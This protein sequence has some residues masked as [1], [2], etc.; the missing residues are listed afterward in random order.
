MQIQ[1]TPKICFATILSLGM[2]VTAWSQAFLPIDNAGFENPV[3][4]PGE[5]TDA[6][7]EWTI[8]D[9]GSVGTVHPTSSD[10]SGGAPE[11]NNVAY[12]NASAN[13]EGIA[14][15]LSDPAAVLK[16]NSQYTLTVQVGNSDFYAFEGYR[17]QLLAGGVVLAE[18]ENTRTPAGGT[19]AL[20][21]VVY[22]YDAAQHAAQLGAPLEIRL[23]STADALGETDFDDVQLA[24][25]FVDPVADTGGPYLAIPGGPLALDASGSTPSIDASITGYEWDLNNDGVFGDVTGVTPA[26]ISFADLQNFWGMELGENT[27]QL[28]VTDS[29]AKTVIATTTVDLRTAAATPGFDFYVDAAEADDVSA[30]W[31]DLT[32][33]NPSGLRLFLDK[34]ADNAVTRQALTTSTTF[35]SH[36]FQFPGGAIGG[37]AG[38]Q[39]V[40]N[41]AKTRQSFQDAGWDTEPV[42][43]EIWIKPDNLTPTPDNGQI[44]FEDG[45][46]TGLGLFLS[47]NQVQARKSPGSGIVSYDIS[48]DPDILLRGP[49][50]DEFIQ[51][52]LTYDPG[53]GELQLFINGAL[54]GSDNPGGDNW[55]GGDN[56]AFGNRGGSHAGGIG[57]GQSA[58][59]SFQGQI[60]VIRGYRNQILTNA[61]VETNFLA[62][63]GPVTIP[64]D[65]TAPN[66]ISFADDVSGGPVNLA[67][68]PTINYTL[69]FDE[70]MLPATIEAA[71]FGNGGTAAFTID[72]IVQQEDP[73][74]AVFLMTVTPTSEGSL[75]LQINQGSTMTDL[76]GNALDTSTSIID[77]TVITVENSA[78]FDTWS[79]GLPAD[80]DANGDGVANAVAWV[81][82]ATDPG[83]NALGLLPSLDNSSDP[84]YVLFSF[85]RLGEAN[86]D[87]D[88]TIA[89]DYSADLGGNW[90]SAVD[91]GDNVLIE[92]TPA[93]PS[94][95]SDT[96]VVKLKRTTLAPAGKLFVRLSVTVNSPAP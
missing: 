24:V 38:A 56:A 79:G 15:I 84:E 57:S 27:I 95:A 69:T 23:L 39:L 62:I 4:N 40:T 12:V 52:V 25:A 7:P 28:K 73:L 58:T 9:S 8:V 1:I 46:D 65:V 82:G 78:V 35:L 63:A 37:V 71:D 42:T 34:S 29:F 6:V 43:F 59:E 49:A 18:D 32:N 80:D 75:Q 16:E 60:A 92:V 94:D 41:S 47:N 91:D 10:Y 93:S 89:V 48:V 14:Q 83:E 86:G 68:N 85:S 13:G 54:V 30:F 77:D 50:T 61:E 44:L 87:P 66:F 36:A 72:S 11:G 90:T 31:N 55:T 33:G 45:G 20:S 22:N 88:T 81:L 74:A 21:T 64:P 2:T 17:V 3:Q 19:F 53:T 96:V 5:F 26:T 51:A 76:N 70:P 67:D